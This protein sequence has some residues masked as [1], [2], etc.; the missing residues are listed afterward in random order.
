MDSEPSPA[1]T[2][3]SREQSAEDALELDTRDGNINLQLVFEPERW[4]F[5]L[6]DALQVAQHT[7]AELGRSKQL[8]ERL[9]VRLVSQPD[10][11]VK[12][13]A[14]SA[15]LLR[16]EVVASDVTQHAERLRRR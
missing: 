11:A 8:S 13:Q 9:D 15:L 1:I 6:Y 7:L 5:L 10:H 12:V 14:A 2:A 3:C 4:L 16:V